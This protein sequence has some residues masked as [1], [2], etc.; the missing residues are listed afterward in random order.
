MSST[1]DARNEYLYEDKRKTLISTMYIASQ[2][3]VFFLLCQCCV[4]P[5]DRPEYLQSLRNNKMPALSS[6]VFTAWVC[7]SGG[8]C[9]CVC[10]CGVC[11]VCVGVCAALLRCLHWL[12]ACVCVCVCV[13][14]VCVVCV[15]CVV[16]GCVCVCVGVRVLCACCVCVV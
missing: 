5:S 9:V 11:C 13:V 10:L 14:C 6:D 3:L 2:N 12:G 4:L 7:V 15:C 1:S 16:R 8:V